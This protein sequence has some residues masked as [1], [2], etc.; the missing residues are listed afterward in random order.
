MQA[1]VVFV[2]L[3]ALSAANYTCYN[4]CGVTNITM[5]SG[6]GEVTSSTPPC[7]QSNST[8][9]QSYCNAC[10]TMELSMSLENTTNGVTTKWSS[11][12][13]YLNLK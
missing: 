3:I 8:H 10:F 1:Q 4:D 12:G 2:A 7:N 6:L 11:E 9:T 13:V 5:V